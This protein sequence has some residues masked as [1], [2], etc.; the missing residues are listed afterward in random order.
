MLLISA[1]LAMTACGACLNQA[2]ELVGTHSAA[3]LA[4]VHAMLDSDARWPCSGEEYTRFE[5]DGVFQSTMGRIGEIWGANAVVSSLTLLFGSPADAVIS[6][7]TL[8]FGSPSSFAMTPHVD[9]PEPSAP[10]ACAGST[11]SDDASYAAAARCTT[12]TGSLT[13]DPAFSGLEVFLPLLASVGGNAVIF[14]SAQLTLLDAPHLVAIGGSLFVD[15]NGNLSSL[16]MPVLNS[17]GGDLFVGNNDK[18]GLMQMPLLGSV[19][20]TID[21]QSNAQLATLGFPLL[22]SVG[23]S[24]VF[25]TNPHLA[26]VHVPL[27]RSVME[28]FYGAEASS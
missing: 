5:I 15:D 28:S 26:S 2:E 20:G 13:I 4:W 16:A 8:L 14:C 11:I 12:I 6:S 17:V 9:E 18:I 23:G 19:G 1:L 22:S 3:A 25:P 10:V 7:L 24:V 27:L 21:V